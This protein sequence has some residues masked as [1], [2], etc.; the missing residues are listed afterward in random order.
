MSVSIATDPRLP[1]LAYVGRHS[2]DGTV[3]RSGPWVEARDGIV[4]D[5]VWDGPFEA[6][7]SED[8]VLWGTAVRAIDASM[9][10]LTSHVPIDRAFLVSVA[11]ATW[12]FSNSL[13][14]V[15]LEA[16]DELS[17]TR[18]DYRSLF[19][20][21]SRGLRHAPRWTSTRR[22]RL[23]RVL[24]G[25]VASLTSG[26]ATFAH[27]PV[28]ASFAHFSHYRARLAKVVDRTVANASDIGRRHLFDPLPMISAGYDSSVVAVLAAEAGVQR[29]ISLRRHL[30][31][32]SGASRD[33][34]LAIADALGLSLTM[35]D[36]GGWRS[37]SDIPEVW[38]AASGMPLFDVALL[39]AEPLLP[40]A[41][42]M[43]GFGGD[44]VW[45]TRPSRRPRDFATS[46]YL[47]G[48][49]L[50]EHRLSVGYAIFAPP[51]ID[52]TAA[53]SLDRITHSPEM[54]PWTL[55]SDYD[56][57]IARRIIESAGVSRGTFAVRKLGVSGGVGTQTRRFR[58]HSPSERLSE[59]TQ[60]MSPAGAES[61][62]DYLED[63]GF[64]DRSFAARRFRLKLAVGAF[65]HH[66]FSKVDAANHRAGRRLPWAHV[67]GPVPRALIVRW[68][69]RVGIH[70][71]YTALLPHWATAQVTSAITGTNSGTSGA[72]N[73]P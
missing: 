24:Y 57:P 14:L 55:G 51:L 40:G 60:T 41:M 23:L 22:G 59:L 73:G 52:A 11:P 9:R 35:V 8:S 48:R 17:P 46:G 63:I 71:D 69:A 42:M 36:R 68:A 49:G 31:G 18:S 21:A 67:G 28:A 26:R 38:V 53:P 25:E 58:G 7:P 29:A 32:E 4:T 15:L 47:F 66:V 39:D 70:P 54:A 64:D 45:S 13:P 16:D 19:H 12:V 56:R 2:P 44:A 43:A 33:D 5:G 65:A 3:I 62:S 34:P 6:G 10:I 30:G 27:R 50:A 1:R 20:S 72:R 37:R 61:Y